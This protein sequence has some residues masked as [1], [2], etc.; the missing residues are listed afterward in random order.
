MNE[1]KKLDL[2]SK[3]FIANGKVYIIETGLS[4]E[5]YSMYEQL[6]IEL[7]YG[8]SFDEMTQKWKDAYNAAQNAK[9]ADVAVIAYNTLN[10]IQ[11]VYDRQPLVL[12]MCALFIN[13]ESEDRRVITTDMI[14]QK[15]E[16]WQEEGLEIGP[17]FQL[18]I[19]IIPGFA[20]HYKQ[21]TQTSSEAIKNNE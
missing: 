20:D 6:Q 4:I 15:I 19:G 2:N 3:N 21:L 17:F 16:D 12:K 1:L 14:I 7:G 11:Q 10:G 5:R 13:E 18:A 8:V 9:L